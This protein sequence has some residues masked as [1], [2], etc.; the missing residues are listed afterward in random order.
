MLRGRISEV[1]AERVE[2]VSLRGSQALGQLGTGCLQAVPR[3]MGIVLGA[4]FAPLRLLLIPSLSGIGK[5]PDGPDR[6]QVPGTPFILEAD[7]GLEY[8]CY[9]RGEVRGGFLRLGDN[10]EV[11]GKIDGSHVVQVNRVANRRTGAIARGY[12]DP[13]ARSAPLKTVLT[14]VLLVFVIVLLVSISES[15]GGR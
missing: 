12:V 5:K 7:D 8:D 1:G 2:T 4:L 15:F 9:L 11:D 14:V 3:A 13:V 6:I 10:V